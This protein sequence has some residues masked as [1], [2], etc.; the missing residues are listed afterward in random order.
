MWCVQRAISFKTP[1]AFT[2]TGKFNI[3]SVCYL[4]VVGDVCECVEMC[5]LMC[6]SLNGVRVCVLVAIGRPKRP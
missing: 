2:V 1:P 3:S 6:M 4:N 5:V